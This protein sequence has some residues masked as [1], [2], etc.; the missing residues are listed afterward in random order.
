M[1]NSLHIFLGYLLCDSYFLFN[2]ID[3]IHSIYKLV[4]YKF[5]FICISLTLKKQKVLKIKFSTEHLRITELLVKYCSLGKTNILFTF[6]T[7]SLSGNTNKNILETTEEG[8]VDLT[9]WVNAETS[10]IYVKPS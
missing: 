2:L 7:H 8:G 4:L 6:T 5:F 9:I 10:V 3:Q 1:V